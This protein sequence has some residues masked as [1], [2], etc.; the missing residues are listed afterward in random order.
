MGG[1]GEAWGKITSITDRQ[2]GVVAHIFNPS[3]EAG[4]SEFKAI[5]VYR[6]SSRTTRL[7]QKNLPQKTKQK[8]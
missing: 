8:S 4:G 1:W 5:L 6:V 7:T 2:L 3:T